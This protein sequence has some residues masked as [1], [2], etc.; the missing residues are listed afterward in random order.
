MEY[1]AR[2][3]DTSIKSGNKSKKAFCFSEYSWPVVPVSASTYKTGKHGAG[4]T[5]MLLKDAF[6]EESFSIILNSD[7]RFIDLEDHSNYAL[8]TGVVTEVDLKNKT[9]T[10]LNKDYQQILIL[11]KDQQLLKVPLDSEVCYMS[12][13]FE[14]ETKYRLKSILN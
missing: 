10:I 7:H 8:E 2:D 1:T 4:K 6:T 9:V 11:V 14:S 3:I 13:T 5:R 12:F